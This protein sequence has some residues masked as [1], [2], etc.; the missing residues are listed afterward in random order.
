MLPLATRK[1][2]AILQV[3]LSCLLAAGPWVDAAGAAPDSRLRFPLT[4]A[5]KRLLDSRGQEF[6]I[7][8]DAPWTLIV[9]LTLEEA[10]AYLAARRAA[11]FNT[12]LVELV[13]PHFTGPR[14]RNGDLPFPEGSPFTAPSRAYFQHAR[15]VIDLALKHHILVLLAHAYVGFGCGKEG[16]CN[17]M[18]R[19]PD[20]TLEDYGRFVGTLLADYPNIIWVHGGD[21]D[22]RVYQAMGK[23][24]AVFR[25]IDAVLPGALHTAHCSRQ[26]S[27]IDCY[28][29]P[30]LKVNTTY[31]ECE[32][33]PAKIVLDRRRA[34][35]MP[36]I[37]IEGRYEEEKD[38]TPRCIQSQLWWSYLGGSAGHVFGNRRIWRFEGD[39]RDALDTPGT[40]AMSVAS[41]LLGRLQAAND[42]LVPGSLA[43]SPLR[44]DVWPS[45]LARALEVS[46]PRRLAWATLAKRPD[47][48]PVASSAATTIAYLPYATRFSYARPGEVLCW[49]DPRTGS[50]RPVAAGTVQ[51]QSPDSL[52]WLFVAEKT[53]RL[54]SG[55]GL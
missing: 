1:H 6:R 12:I 37:Y 16:W 26:F 15:A 14:N 8:G 53:L 9:A 29:R 40:R 27:A 41:K 7:V 39:W 5:G 31:S 2:A 51:L 54:C 50:I 42:E 22:A 19:T 38:A 46:Y 32:Q 24:E 44:M 30:W 18:L 28:D 47:E 13:E 3:L 43:D 4:V 35:A 10:D 49:I 36:S 48:I 25:G 33:T 20:A 21:V 52:D 34:A 45:A 11:G 55:A 17:A 23:V